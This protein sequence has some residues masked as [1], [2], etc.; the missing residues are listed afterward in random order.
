MTNSTASN[1]LLKNWR[2]FGYVCL[3][4]IVPMLLCL[5]TTMLPTTPE[6]ICQVYPMPT[7]EK[8]IPSTLEAPPPTQVYP[9]Q[10]VTVR[11]SGGYLI[12]NYQI[13]C[14]DGEDNYVGGGYAHGDRLAWSGYTRTTSIRLSASDEQCEIEYVVPPDKPYYAVVCGDGDV[15]GYVRQDNLPRFVYSRTVSVYL[16]AYPSVYRD[17]DP[18]TSTECGNEC[19]LEFAI[20]SD[21]SPS[22]HKL[23][24][25]SSPF[26]GLGGK[27]EFDIEVV[28]K[29]TTTP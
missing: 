8:S 5:A 26:T 6:T 27:F 16:D 24:I 12:Y 15:V 18:L 14:F 9:G 3:F 7:G 4:A 13:G 2:F 22:I 21:T 25:L 23:E 11:F 29:G 10:L 17:E 28:E 20:P 19:R 1:R